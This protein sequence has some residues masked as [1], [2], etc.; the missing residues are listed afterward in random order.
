ME[1]II[2]PNKR[3]NREGSAGWVTKNGIK[4]W[5]ITMSNGYNPLTGNLKRKYIYGKTQKDAKDK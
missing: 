5:C 4:Y 1:G 3:S 2:M